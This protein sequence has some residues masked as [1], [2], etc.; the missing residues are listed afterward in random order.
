[1]KLKLSQTPNAP[2]DEP[3]R[4]DNV[5]GLSTIITSKA[6]STTSTNVSNVANAIS[7]MNTNTRANINSR[8]VAAESSMNTAH[9][10]NTE[11]DDD[12][13]DDN[14]SDEEEEEEDT[15]SSSGSSIDGEN[16]DM[17]VISMSNIRQI[18]NDSFVSISAAGAG[19]LGM[20]IP[21]RSPLSVIGGL[22]VIQDGVDNDVA[23]LPPLPR[24]S[25]IGSDSG[26][27]NGDFPRIASGFSNNSNGS[28]SNYSI[29][30]SAMAQNGYN[31]YNRQNSEVMMRQVGAFAS[32]NEMN[33]QV[34]GGFQDNPIVNLVSRFVQWQ[35]ANESATPG[36]DNEAAALEMMSQSY[37]K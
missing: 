14:G 19:K 11:D 32:A 28:N 1:M 8:H 36:N 37:Q 29:D 16:S 10:Y 13:D 3:H 33:E 12:H 24:V 30:V 4:N 15:S 23:G 34:I 7:D 5:G 20:A 22:Q 17:I 35:R 18:S 27:F 6:I 26:Y 21:P 9:L 2:S 25:S 31:N